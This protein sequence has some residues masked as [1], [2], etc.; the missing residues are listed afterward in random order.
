[1][2]S[3]VLGFGNEITKTLQA[4]TCAK[5]DESKLHSVNDYLNDMF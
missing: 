3:T 1:M 5:M 2:G 4:S